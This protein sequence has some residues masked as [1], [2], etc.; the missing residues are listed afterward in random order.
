MTT[1]CAYETQQDLQLLDNHVCCIL[2]MLE[3]L[4]VSHRFFYDSVTVCL[5]DQVD[6]SL[7]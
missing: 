4:R 2:I 5:T 3:M 7:G 1:P 6:L